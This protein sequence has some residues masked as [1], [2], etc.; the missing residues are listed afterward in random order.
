MHNTMKRNH[1]QSASNV[2][3]AAMTH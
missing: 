2:A 1:I 3:Y